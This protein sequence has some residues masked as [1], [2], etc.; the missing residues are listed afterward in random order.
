[1]HIFANPVTYSARVMMFIIYAGL[2]MDVRVIAT[3]C[4][5]SSL[6]FYF[7]IA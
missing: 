7:T 4:T 6:G 1:M 3:T 2:L 5:D